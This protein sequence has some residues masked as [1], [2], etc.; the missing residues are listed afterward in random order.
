MN[1][2]E[3]ISFFKT[4]R[5]ILCIWPINSK[6]I[7][8]KCKSG[9]T[10]EQWTQLIQSINFVWES[11]TEEAFRMNWQHFKDRKLISTELL[12]YIENQWITKRRYFARYKIDNYMH[13]HHY[14]SSRVEGAHSKL[15]AFLESGTGTL[16]NCWTKMKEGIKCMENEHNAALAKERKD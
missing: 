10:E 16:L 1:G 7:A 4:A 2:L 8:G 13:F 14:V 3:S 6:N 5:N 9:L 12:E 15:K 11:P